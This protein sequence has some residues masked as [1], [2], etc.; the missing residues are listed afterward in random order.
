MIIAIAVSGSKANTYPKYSPLSYSLTDTYAGIS[1][2]DNFD[3]FSGVDPAGGFVHYVDGP[4][5]VAQNLTHASA[6]SAVLRVQNTNTN[7]STGRRS[8]RTERKNTYNTGLFVFDV[9]HSPYGCSTWPAL[10]LADPYNWPMNGE[11]DVMEA[12][13]TAILAIK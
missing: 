4:S 2:F 7:T 6:T 1:F 12:T 9:L 13:N 10:W 3:Y 11:I 8:V 5:S